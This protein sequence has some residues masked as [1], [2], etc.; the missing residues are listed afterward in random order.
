MRLLPALLGALV[1]FSA[2][3]GGSPSCPV[4]EDLNTWRIVGSVE[5]DPACSSRGTIH[6]ANDNEFV[7]LVKNVPGP[8]TAEAIFNLA[9]DPADGNL[10][11]GIFDAG[12]R[13]ALSKG[14]LASQTLRASWAKPGMFGIIVGGQAIRACD[15]RFSILIK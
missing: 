7:Y 14:Q 6:M 9:C 4:G 3:G 12:S 5:V 8:V 10:D 1:L 11:L 13:V 15:A 2:C